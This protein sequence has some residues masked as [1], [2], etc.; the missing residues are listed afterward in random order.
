MVSGIV[1]S[2]RFTLVA[3]VDISPYTSETVI[4]IKFKADDCNAESISVR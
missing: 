1:V 3:D 4:D 2:E